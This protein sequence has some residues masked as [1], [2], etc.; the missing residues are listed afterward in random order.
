MKKVRRP[1]LLSCFLLITGFVFIVHGQQKVIPPPESD[2]TSS[3]RDIIKYLARFELGLAHGQYKISSTMAEFICTGL[4]IPIDLQAGI[5]IF[6]KTYIHGEFGATILD[7]P[8]YTLNDI[9]QTLES[10]ISMFDLGIGFTV[11]PLPQKVYTSATIYGTTTVLFTEEET[12]NSEVGVAFKL[13]GGVD[14]MVGSAFSFGMSA[15]FYYA[16]MKDQPDAD[17]YQAQINN[18]VLGICFTATL[19]NL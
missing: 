18:L 1:V 4:A 8:T 7:R 6:P 11:Y 5:G 17:G 3:N 13:R 14:L 2:R 10:T 9:E 12:F 16:G 19:G 15:F